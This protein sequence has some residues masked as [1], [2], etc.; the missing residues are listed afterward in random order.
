VKENFSE[1]S[2]K[3]M[4][5]E[6]SVELVAFMNQPEN[7]DKLVE[8]IT[9]LLSKDGP[10]NPMISMFLQ[11]TVSSINLEESFKPYQEG[12]TN[13]VSKKLYPVMSRKMPEIVKKAIPENLIEDKIRETVKNMDESK[14]EKIIKD[15]TRKELILIKWSGAV[16]GGLIGVVQILLS[17]MK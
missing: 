16:L 8:F 4:V 10:P 9:S 2:L 3:G 7:K 13:T 5:S 15:I 17:M 6:S 11:G 1:E 14:I 12:I